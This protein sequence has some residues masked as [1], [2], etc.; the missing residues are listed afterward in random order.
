MFDARK[1]K[2]IPQFFLHML[3]NILIII[4]KT[5]IMILQV[6]LNFHHLNLIKSV[7][8]VF[9]SPFLQRK[10]FPHTSQ[11]SYKRKT[12]LIYCLHVSILKVC[13]A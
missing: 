11:L 6:L 2:D 1:K 7:L 5:I 4:I 8:I 12:Q 10:F 9:T 3:H 13:S